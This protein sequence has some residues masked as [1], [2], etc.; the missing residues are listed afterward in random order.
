MG[1]IEEDIFWD[2]TPC[3]PLKVNR[4]FGEHVASIL[5]DKE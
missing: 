2:I 3:I 1:K 5:S 4:R